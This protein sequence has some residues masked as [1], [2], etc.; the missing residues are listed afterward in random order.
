M[1]SEK[2]NYFMQFALKEAQKAYEQGE[3]PV[4]CVI[5]H[6]GKIIAKSHNTV[7]QLKDPTAHA[8]ILA[9]GIA[10]AY[11]DNWRLINAK[12]YCTLEPC[13]MC[14]GAIQLARISTIVWGAKDLRLGAN[15]SWFDVFKEKH[16]FHQ[17]SCHSGILASESE[18][19]MKQFFLEQR[20]KKK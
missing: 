11:L 7:E 5:V 19:L 17:V 13:L 9:I 4:G 14:A 10:A 8:E 12:M 15:G 1:S 3:V 16:P 18:Y 2:D 20:L 6:E